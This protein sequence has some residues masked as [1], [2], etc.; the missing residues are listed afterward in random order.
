MKRLALVLTLLSAG[1]ALATPSGKKWFL[2]QCST[3]CYPG[4][5]CSNSR[6]LS[7]YRIAASVE[8]R[9]G[10]T[11]AGAQGVAAATVVSRTQEAF[12]NW[13]AA[14][15]TGCTTAWDVVYG[16]TYSTPQGTTGVNGSDGCNRH[17]E[18]LE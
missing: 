6:C 1:A 14:R 16:G 11:I 7:V 12:R 4:M 18:P 9:G 3:T 2:S 13:I 17:S 15:V 5:Q 10:M 8:N